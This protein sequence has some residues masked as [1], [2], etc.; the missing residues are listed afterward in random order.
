MKTHD[1]LPPEALSR[2]TADSHIKQVPEQEQVSQEELRETLLR[3]KSQLEVARNAARAEARARIEERDEARASKQKADQEIL[4]LRRQIARLNTVL[5]AERRRA[6]SVEAELRSKEGAAAREKA[7]VADGDMSDA[8][9]I[10]ASPLFDA[11]WYRKRH[12]DAGETA[13]AAAIHFLS[14]NP[15]EPRDPGPKFD[16]KWYLEQNPD[17]GASD[18]NPLVHYLR[19]GAA[20]GR[21]IRPVAI[22][23]ATEAERELER[24]IQLIKDSPLFDEE[25]YYEQNADV[26]GVGVSAA[27]HYLKFGAAEGRNPGPNFDGKWY[28]NRYPD[29]AAGNFN[30]LVHYIEWGAAE[31]REIRPVSMDETGGPAIAALESVRTRYSN[32]SPLNVLMLRGSTRRLN[33][34]TDSVNSGSLFG[35]VGTALILGAL[36]ARRLNM[37]LRIVTRKEVSNAQNIDDVLRVNGID[38]DQNIEFAHS[39]HQNAACV[40]ISEQDL[41]LTT[42]WW[43]T[44]PALGSVPKQKI[45][46]LLQEDERMF[47]PFGDERL[48][49]RETLENG[50]VHFIVN[51]QLLFQ[52]FISGCEPLRNFENKAVWFEP[53][54]PSSHYHAEPSRLNAT[55]KRNFFFY[56]R[57]QNARN[58]Y[59]RGLES[60]NAAIEERILTADEWE[61]Y[62]AGRLLENVIFPGGITPTLMEN[63]PWA[64]YAALVRQ[65]D[66][67]LCLMET[68]HPS[69]PPLDLAASGGVVVTNRHGIKTSLDGYSRNIICAEPTVEGLKEAIRTAGRIA[70]DPK[71]RLENYQRNTLQR[72]WIAA[73]TPA[74]DATLARMGVRA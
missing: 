26:A 39:P 4:E 37:P 40:P 60:I 74:I 15:K 32:L 45:I 48:R 61:I 16:A 43:T 67:G 12:P 50:D 68:P 1:T 6:E 2:E 69:Y 46:Y 18:L 34:V 47:Y 44:K 59:Y 49:C 31:G 71:T 65:M 52:H 13:L 41:F 17:L 66:V 27:A 7:G 33:I 11:A 35:G 55:G 8:E 29:V 54:F 23:A 9:L 22:S 53:A 25:W 20:E 64:E 72:D 24:Q 21:K 51:S 56:A 38:W 36:L 58:L 70:C 62:F 5:E 73:L 19:F 57:P 28:R 10:A 30:P 3:L 14:A 63:L 42:S